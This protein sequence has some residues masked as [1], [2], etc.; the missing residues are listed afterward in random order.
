MG[1]PKKMEDGEIKVA[2]TVEH[3]GCVIDMLGR[4]AMVDEGRALV[5]GRMPMETN[6]V[7]CGT[8]AWCMREAQQCECWQVGRGS[9]TRVLSNIYVA[10][11]I[12]R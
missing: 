8:F 12:V 11:G 7:I 5:E 4:M 2:Q 6:V 3:C 9:T 10:A 1:L